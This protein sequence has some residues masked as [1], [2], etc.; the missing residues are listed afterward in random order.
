YLRL[1]GGKGVATGAGATAALLP[2]PLAAAALTWLVAL[3]IWRIV[4]VAS[5]ASAVAFIAAF[6]AIGP[7][8]QFSPQ[9]LPVT[10]YALALSAL[11]ILRHKS[12]IRRLL[13]GKEPRIGEKRASKASS[14]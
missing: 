8:P 4:S 6:F 12:N 9:I 11:V 2:L 10:V 14:G 3:L 5:M 13:Q 7:A 1:R